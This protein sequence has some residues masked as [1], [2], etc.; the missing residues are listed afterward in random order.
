MGVDAGSDDRR[1]LALLDMDKMPL[2]S[3]GRPA[4][5]AADRW[6]RYLG[7][8]GGIIAFL[9]LYFLP[10][11][12]GLSV[13]GQSG[14]ASFALA[15]VWWV[16]EPFPT[17]LTSLVLMFLL[18]ATGASAPKPILDVLGMD[19]IWLNLLAFILAAMLV[20]TRL[21]RRLALALVIRFGSTARWALFAFVVL[22]LAL[23]PLIPATAARAVMTLPLML[24][25]AAIYGSTED[26]PNAFG[27]NLMLLNLIGISVL[28]STSMT[29]SSANMIAAGFIQTMGGE[30]VYYFD[31]M[32]LG[33]PIAIATTLLMWVVG[34]RWIFPIAPA[35][36]TPKIPGG[37]EMIRQK[38]AEMGP[39]SVP[40]RKAIAVFV[41]VLFLW[42]TDALHQRWFGVD[43]TPPFAALLGVVV[44]LFP[45][46]G[47][48]TWAE[49]DIPWHLLI[50]SAGAYAGGL[51]LD[52]TGAAEWLVRSLFGRFD[53]QH[54]P[55][56]V[57]YTIIVATMMYSHL[58]TTSKTV[59]TMIMI[60]IIIT[61]ARTLGWTPMSLALPAALT[62]D[63]VIGLP[64]NGKPNVIL[65][66]TN[67][68]S[69][70][71]NFKYGIVACTI[72]LVLLVAS[73]AT[74]FHWLGV[75]PSF[76]ATPP[77]SAVSAGA[78]VHPG[79]VE[80]AARAWPSLLWLVT[81]AGLSA[82]Y[83]YGFRDLARRAS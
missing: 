17:Y 68:Y 13:T 79:N 10:L 11:G 53:L 14:L 31:W 80:A 49:S 25:I 20:K 66:S 50:F 61:L 12:A 59:R 19:V 2:S 52:S 22:Q 32:R 33:A 34:Q 7:F 69:V 58:L 54:L 41:L 35:D 23:A 74:W 42:T 37:L 29:G 26:T 36:R 16:T 3:A 73:G 56:G 21:A 4:Q 60:P 48:L 71:D 43:I 78:A 38:H 63:W 30:R 76:F 39:L 27:K 6:M 81:G 72:G 82:A 47:V 67:Q 44:A 77:L 9:L 40:E 5:S 1:L 75:T 45:R 8:P 28:S 64:I 83:L 70:V 57:V 18:L 51:A 15:L 62:I 24:V 65:F 55:F 46:W